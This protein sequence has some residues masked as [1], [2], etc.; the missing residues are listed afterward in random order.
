[1]ANTPSSIQPSISASN[2]QPPEVR[3]RRS[4]IGQREESAPR[5]TIRPSDDDGQ[6]SVVGKEDKPKVGTQETGLPSGQSRFSF[7][8]D[9]EEKEVEPISELYSRLKLARQER[10]QQLIRENKRVK[11]ERCSTCEAWNSKESERKCKVCG[12]DPQPTCSCGASVVYGA[13]CKDCQKT[14]CL[15]WLRGGM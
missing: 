6:R 14:S 11:S 12:R 7:E 10:E 4:T 9:L 5:K 2:L 15:D 3:K 1:M 13:M 8:S